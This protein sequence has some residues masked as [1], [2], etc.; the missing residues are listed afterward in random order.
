VLACGDAEPIPSPAPAIYDDLHSVS[1][2][3]ADHV[4]A[5]GDHRAAWWS[6][7]GGETWTQLLPA[8]RASGG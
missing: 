4:V 5:V 8:P 7:D 2:S 6:E 3:D 1:V